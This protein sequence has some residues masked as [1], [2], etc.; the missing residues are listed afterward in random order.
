[1]ARSPGIADGALRIL[2]VGSGGREHAIA[3]KLAQSRHQPDLIIAP[4]NAGTA[5]LGENVPV[6]AIDL[7]GMVALAKERHVDLVVIGP[8]APLAAGLADRLREAGARVFGP[9]AAA[10]KIESSKVW[11]KQLMARHGMPT[12]PA[13]SFDDP[14]KARAY[15]ASRPEGSV[16]IKAD[17]LA[18]GKGV[19][20]PQTRAETFSA[21]DSLMISQAAG[22]A[23]KKVLIEER[24]SGPE[25]S[26]F[27]FVCG[28]SVS[29]EIAACDYKRVN[30]GDQGPN[31]GGMGSYTPPE[32]W[33]PE[34]AARVRSRILIPAARAM[35]QEGCPFNGVLYAGL[36]LTDEGPKVIEFNC[37]LGDPEAEVVLPRLSSDLVDVC[38][39]IAD[40]QPG[41]APVK[42][43]E[44]AHVG[45]V[46]ASGGYPGKYQNG[47]PVTGLEEAS[48]DAVVFHAGTK[49]VPEDQ[50]LTNGGRVLVAVGAG[51][52]V[53]EAREKAYSAVSKISFE[54]AHYRR[55]IAERAMGPAGRKIIPG[56]DLSGPNETG[57]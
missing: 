32:F 42:W 6:S 39:A 25:V 18:A 26:V 11:A 16:V 40:S 28:E 37:R 14:E 36:M 29:A 1:M 55:D 35:V 56:A 45:V 17:G 7:E 41:K 54:G 4:G 30:D 13:R 50:V 34:L 38:M 27:A 9:S 24:L 2:V 23:G 3:W 47:F 8:E 51:Q 22:D 57:A 5:A 44:R 46:M 43:D 15:A 31:T 53:A 48:K 12:A 21:I 19:V 20:I 52:N 49:H 10:A 33:T